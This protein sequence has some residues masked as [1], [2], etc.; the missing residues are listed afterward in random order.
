MIFYSNFLKRRSF[1]KGPRWDMI[2]LVLSRKMVFY[3]QK[4]DI[5]SLGK[6]REAALLRK[7]M[8]I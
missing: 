7:Y 6:K 4:N 8:E 5:F 2:F 1:E 3:F